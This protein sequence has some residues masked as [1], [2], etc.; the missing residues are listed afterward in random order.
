M[1][2]YDYFGEAALFHD[3]NRVCTVTAETDV[4]ILVSC[5]IF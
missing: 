2:P 5:L 3:S 1:E 4:N